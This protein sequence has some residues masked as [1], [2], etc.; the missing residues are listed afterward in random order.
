MTKTEQM[1]SDNNGK[2]E[3]NQIMN[4]KGAEEAK[5]KYSDFEFRILCAEL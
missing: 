4:R 1:N 5:K 3:T 2:S